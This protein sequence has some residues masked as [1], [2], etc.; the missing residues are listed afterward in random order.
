LGSFQ[1]P[2]YSAVLSQDGS[3]L[4]TVDAASNVFAY[5][6]T[7]FAQKGWVSN[8]DFVDQQQSVV[9]SVT[10]ETGLIFGSIGH[11]VAFVDASAI[12]TGAQGTQFN[13]GFLSPDTGPL[14]GGTEIQSEVLT[15]VPVPSITTGTVYIGNAATTSVSKEILWRIKGCRELQI[16]RSTLISNDDW[17]GF[18]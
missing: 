12:N 16:V 9:A 6:T 8:F 17:K 18:G 7:T 15:G 1:P 3:T 5:D 11:G 10:D 4:F 14:S 2:G 13:I